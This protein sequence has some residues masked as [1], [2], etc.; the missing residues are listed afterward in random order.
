MHGGKAALECREAGLGPDRVERRVRLG[1]RDRVAEH[2]HEVV[3][4]PAPATPIAGVE[5]GID[6]EPHV[7]QLLRA[8]VRDG[9]AQAGDLVVARQRPGVRLLHDRDLE[10]A[11]AF[12][13]LVGELDRLLLV[14][15][16]AAGRGLLRGEAQVLVDLAVTVV[17]DAVQELLVDPAVAV[18]V[19]H[20]AR[21]AVAGVA[22]TYDIRVRQGGTELEHRAA[23][24]PLRAV[25]AHRTDP[26]LGV[27]QALVARALGE[28]ERRV[29]RQPLVEEGVADH[30]DVRD[31]HPEPTGI[32][33]RAIVRDVH[34]GVRDSGREHECGYTRP[35]HRR[36]GTETRSKGRGPAGSAGPQLTGFH[37]GP[38]S[39]RPRALAASMDAGQD[40][41]RER[42]A[43]AAQR[44]VLDSVVQRS[45]RT[46]GRGG[47]STLR[48]VASKPSTTQPAPRDWKVTRNASE[49]PRKNT[50]SEALASLPGAARQRPS[51]G[52]CHS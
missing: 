31:A 7:T 14:V 24:D 9:E 27:F 12:A 38:R 46:P 51:A 22:A 28:L 30:A 4:V 26:Q 37:S 21:P 43:S 5:V 23:R 50:I 3:G 29:E 13:V 32:Q 16:I 42:A 39:R 18:V 40:S 34:L 35:S 10:R 36:D 45:N 1:D 33:D 41:A 8:V 44:G 52:S 47:Y 49:R 19:E 11:M 48:V 2:G 25:L 20:R 6:P 15:G 17:V